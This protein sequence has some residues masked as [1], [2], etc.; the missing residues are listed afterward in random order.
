MKIDLTKG[1]IS[2]SLILFS[3][4]M[5]MG[6]LIQQLYNI[7]DTV[8][9]GKTIGKVA[10]SAV[11]S[12]YSLIILFTSI[13][14]GL[15]MGGGIIFAK[16]YGSK[17]IEKLKTNIFNGFILILSITVVINVLCY[18]LL[19]WFIM[20]LNIPTEAVASTKIYLNVMFSGMIFVFIYNFFSSILRSVGNTVTPLIFLVISSILNIVLDLVFILKFDM[21]VYGA[22]LATVISQCVSAI[23]VVAYFFIAERGLCPRKEHMKIDVNA[24]KSISSISIL[25][26]IQQSI[27]NFGI[28]MIQGLVNSFGLIVSASFATVV[29]IDAFAYMPAQDFGN[30]FATYVAQNNG[31]NDNKRIKEGMK[32]AVIISSIFCLIVSVVVVVFANQLMHIF[33]DKNEIEII[34]IGV[35]YLRIEGACYVGIGILFLLY[36]YFRGLGKPVISIILTIVSLGLRVLLAYVLCLIPALG[37]TGI[38]LSI[39]IGW[40]IADIIGFILI[41]REKTRAR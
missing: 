30:A 14:L 38:W 16:L 18:I 27:M 36:A 17:A 32:K 31:A 25:T 21:G 39:P 37:I 6:N 3:L 35:D 4:P 24:M 15:C 5:I 1:K 29:K 9:V 40:L 20:L 33:I 13:I 22:G 28:L 10:L 19:D 34:K 41:K 26:S 11:G 2:K 23:L 7:V 8:I 12:A